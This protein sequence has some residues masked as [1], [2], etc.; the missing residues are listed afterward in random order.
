MV[1]PLD[2]ANWRRVVGEADVSSGE[3]CQQPPG[4]SRGGRP[5]AHRWAR[6]EW[7]GEEVDSSGVASAGGGWG[8]EEGGWGKRSTE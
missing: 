2:L 1:G 8:V 6:C 5:E 3:H 4:N 7:A